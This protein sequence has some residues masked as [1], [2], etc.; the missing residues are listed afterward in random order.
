[1]K[2]VDYAG[3][4]EKMHDQ[5]LSGDDLS[6]FEF[7][8]VVYKR[9]PMDSDSYSDVF[10]EWEDSESDTESACSQQRCET[11]LDNKL[12]SGA[13]ITSS[14]SAVQLLS[15]VFKHKLTRE[16]FNNLL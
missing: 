10:S 7:T 8:D 4:C 2:N 14:S 9:F 16:A 3:D 12:Y 15:S 1:M 5:K 6:D 13:P 11:E